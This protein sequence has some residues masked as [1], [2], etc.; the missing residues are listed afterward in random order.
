VAVM[1]LQRVFRELREK[2]VASS[3]ESVGEFWLRELAQPVV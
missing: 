3:A 2:K 1:Y